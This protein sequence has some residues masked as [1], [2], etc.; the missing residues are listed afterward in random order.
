METQVTKGEVNLNHT[1]WR[2]IEKNVYQ[3]PF[4]SS[5]LLDLKLGYTHTH[6]TL[7][8]DVEV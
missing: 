6:V 8:T 7:E 4:Q 5:S 1:Q 2:M 3:N